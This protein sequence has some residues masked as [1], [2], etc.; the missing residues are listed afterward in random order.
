MEDKCN[1]GIAVF[2]SFFV[3]CVAETELFQHI[4]DS[5]KRVKYVKFAWIGVCKRESHG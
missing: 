4:C 5:L 1:R 2:R 3:A